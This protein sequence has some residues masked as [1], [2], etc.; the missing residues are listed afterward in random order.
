MSDDLR[1][2]HSRSAEA[3]SQFDRAEAEPQG[4]GEVLP[5]VAIEHPESSEVKLAI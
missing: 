3:R 1:E 4:C 2:I 5:A